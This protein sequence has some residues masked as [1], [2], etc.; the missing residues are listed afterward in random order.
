MV[1]EQL[2]QGL[3]QVTVQPG[4]IVPVQ[5]V[6]PVSA[7]GR[8]TPYL[9]DNL[10]AVLIVIVPGTFAATADCGVLDSH[11]E[12]WVSQGSDVA[13]GSTSLSQATAMVSFPEGRSYRWLSINLTALSGTLPQFWLT[14][15]Q[16][17]T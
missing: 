4:A 9:I 6:L 3:G 17:S 8:G 7:P 1:C 11:L 13:S 16:R 10:I 2:S 12:A 5:L 14:G 15:R